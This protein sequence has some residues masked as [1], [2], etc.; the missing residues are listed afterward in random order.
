[1]N[2]KKAR[3]EG[4]R[5]NIQEVVSDHITAEEWV[6]LAV[7]GRTEKGW[8]RECGKEHKTDTWTTTWKLSS[9]SVTA[10]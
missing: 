10:N 9:V 5:G 8:A 1:M 2:K 3:K 4:Q 7:L 6:H